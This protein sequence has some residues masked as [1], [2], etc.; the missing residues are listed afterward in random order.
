MRHAL[1]G[2]AWRFRY[3]VSLVKVLPNPI[4][5]LPRKEGGLCND[6]MRLAPVCLAVIQ[7]LQ[8]P[9]E[10][11]EEAGALC[12]NVNG[13]YLVRDDPVQTPAKVV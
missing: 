2:K 3:L 12:A 8:D 7:D 4:V 1:G 9:G 10:M 5:P 13:K 6:N 11:G